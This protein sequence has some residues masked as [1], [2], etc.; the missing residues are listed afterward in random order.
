MEKEKCVAEQGIYDD[1]MF[2]YKN[3]TVQSYLL[4]WDLM[5][6]DCNMYLKE[7]R[8]ILRPMSLIGNEITHKGYNNDK[9]FIP[10][11]K[12]KEMLSAEDNDFEDSIINTTRVKYAPSEFWFGSMQIILDFLNMLHFDT[13]DLITKGAA[14]STEEVGDV[15]DVNYEIKYE[16]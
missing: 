6:R 2:Y 16:N 8:L 14:V 10:S 7:L 5:H 3:S 13:R 9:P 12:I 4:N 1:F 15:Y 11:E